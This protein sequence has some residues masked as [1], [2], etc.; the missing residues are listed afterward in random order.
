[1]RQF[2]LVFLA[3]CVFVLTAGPA[4]AEDDKE[5]R[6][7]YRDS[8][9]LEMKRQYA[10]AIK[11]MLEV[12]R[13]SPGE[14]LPNLRLG[15]LYYLSGAHDDAK[16]YYQNAMKLSPESL[17]ARLG[18]ILPLVAQEDYEEVEVVA[19]QI[20]EVDQ[21]NYYASLRLVFAL[22]MQEKYEEADTIASEMLSLYPT[23]VSYLTEGGFIKKAL[24]QEEAARELF[25]LVLLLQP[26]NR[27]A[28]REVEGR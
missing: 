15:W 5:V 21:S 20:L 18:Y 17:E 2:W 6:R 25:N 19:K 8:Y 11:I 27:T 26:N 4:G 7:Q 28:R 10:D 1:M 16:L 24:G 3:A 12:R 9:R 13:E 23:D 22:R 14:Y